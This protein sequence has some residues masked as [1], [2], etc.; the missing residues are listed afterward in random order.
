MDLNRYAEGVN[1][2]PTMMM[3]PVSPVSM[4]SFLLNLFFDF[5]PEYPNTY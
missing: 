5:I 2:E 1:T 4:G 3:M